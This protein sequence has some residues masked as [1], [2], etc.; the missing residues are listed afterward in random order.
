MRIVYTKHASE[1]VLRPDVRK[2]KIN[3]KLIRS[4]LLNPEVRSRTK[5]GEFCA[6]SKIDSRHDLRV[7]YDIIGEDTKVITFHVSAEGRYR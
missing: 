7:I 5:S 6:I 3:K 2:I 1:K 4:I